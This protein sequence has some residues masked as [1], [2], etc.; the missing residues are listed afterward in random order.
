MIA[1]PPHR[2][3]SAPRRRSGTSRSAFGFVT[4]S[5][6]V[7]KSLSA[8]RSAL[9]KP[10]WHWC[11]TQRR[12]TSASSFPAANCRSE[13][14]GRGVLDGRTFAVKD[15]IDVAGCRTGAGNPT[16]IA[17][18]APAERSASVVEKTLAAGATLVG[19]TIT[20]ELAFSLEGRNVHYD[21]LINPVCPDRLPGGSSSGS[22]VAVAAGTRRFRARHRHRR[23]GP[24]AREFPRP[25]RIPSEPRRNPARWR[26]TVRAIVRYCR[27]VRAR[28]RTAGGCRGGAAPAT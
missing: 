1:A 21:V 7:I 10:R 4:G 20:D 14:T 5:D 9:R 18:Q 24:R 16:W 19:K 17:Q 22:A 23:V 25:V 2:R 3:I 8:G 6:A 12:P 28:R 15:L 26:R 11:R 13:A 27:M